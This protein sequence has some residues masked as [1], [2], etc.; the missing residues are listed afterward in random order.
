MTAITYSIC[1]RP[2]T[3][4]FRIIFCSNACDM[5]GGRMVTASM[6][7]GAIWFISASY[8][9]TNAPYIFAIKNLQFLP[10][11]RSIG[12]WICLT[13]KTYTCQTV[14]NTI[15]YDIRFT[16]MKVRYTI[17]EQVTM[18]NNAKRTLRKLQRFIS[19][20]ILL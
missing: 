7:V 10:C 4:K 1:R 8:R 17:F 9:T 5:N 15:R 2:P 11:G 12:S 3:E 16:R 13:H 20:A 6:S 19:T 14:Q 18:Y